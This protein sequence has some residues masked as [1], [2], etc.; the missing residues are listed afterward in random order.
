MVFAKRRGCTLTKDSG[1]GLRGDGV[2]IW[3]W[4]NA[5]SLLCLGSPST[6]IPRPCHVVDKGV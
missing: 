3:R 6:L 5:C 1:T 2:Y 4:F